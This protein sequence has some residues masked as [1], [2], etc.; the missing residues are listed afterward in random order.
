MRCWRE[1]ERDRPVGDQTPVLHGAADKVWDGD[2]VLFRQRVGNVVVVS[3]EVS[4]VGPDIQGVAHSVLLLWGGVHSELGLV[5]GG[6]LLL[7][8]E[9]TDNEASQVSDHRN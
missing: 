8:L 4:D 7:V 9:I 3:E 5:E 2:H 6:Q 1:R